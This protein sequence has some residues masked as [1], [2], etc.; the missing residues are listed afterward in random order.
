MSN[1]SALNEV[2]KLKNQTKTIRRKRYGKSRLDRYK[3]QLITLRDNGASIAEL[4][5]WLRAKRIKVEWSTVS[6]WLNKNG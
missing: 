4:Q 1:F 6:R 3:K 2:K 5:R